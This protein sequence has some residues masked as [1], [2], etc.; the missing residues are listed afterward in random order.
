MSEEQEYQVKAQAN[1][2]ESKFRIQADEYLQKMEEF[3]KLEKKMKQ[4]EANIKDYM[5]TNNLREYR[6]EIG[7]FTIVTKKMNVLNKAL[8]EDIEQYYSETRRTIMYKSIN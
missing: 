1:L 4:Y 7:S 5:I 2:T 3:K 6:N 8:I